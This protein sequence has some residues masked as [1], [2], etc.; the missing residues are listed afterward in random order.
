MAKKEVTTVTTIRI[1][2]IEKV[3]ERFLEQLISEEK[4]PYKQKQAAESM[5]N[6]LGVDNV[7]ITDVQQ[8]VRD[9][10]TVPSVKLIFDSEDRMREVLES[11]NGV[12]PSNFRLP[13]ISQ[14]EGWYNT[15]EC[16]RCWKQSGAVFEVSGGQ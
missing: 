14:C 3:D 16:K 12:C 6:F 11:L 1:T 7:V 5:R 13:G 2:S 4:D 8:F 10:N 9:I 15:D